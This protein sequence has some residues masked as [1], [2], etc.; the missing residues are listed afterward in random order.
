MQIISAYAFQNDCIWDNKSKLTSDW[1][2]WGYSLTYCFNRGHT[3]KCLLQFSA[4]QQC[5]SMMIQLTVWHVA[6]LVQMFYSLCYVRVKFVVLFVVS[7]QFCKLKKQMTKYWMH[8]FSYPIDNFS[9]PPTLTHLHKHICG[10]IA[11]HTH[12]V[13]H[14]NV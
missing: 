2:I 3:L 8:Y 9:S 5:W 14:V 6:Q 12:S 10:D 7:F 11:F 4:R 1:N 13:R